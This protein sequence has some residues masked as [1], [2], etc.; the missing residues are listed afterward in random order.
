MKEKYNDIG[1]TY[2]Q[3]RKADKR[4][5]QRIINELELDPGSK[6]LDV[7]AGTGNY[8]YELAKIGYEITALEPSEVMIN[9]GK[10]HDNLKWYKGIAEEIPFSEKTFDGITCILST[11]H[12]KDLRKS[13]DEIKRVL[14]DNG[15]AVIFTADPRLCP[16]NFWY[17]NY[18]KD[19]IEKSYKI[20]PPAQELKAMLAKAFNNNVEMTTFLIPYDLQDGF[21]F[22]AWRYPE[23][24]LDMTFCNGISSLAET[25][26][27]ILIK[28]QEKLRDD[29]NNGNWQYRYRNILNSNE[30][31][32]GYLFLRVKAPRLPWL[33]QGRGGEPII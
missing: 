16:N 17:N 18:F 28:T 2:N 21:F 30:Y 20:H 23:R 29:L 1:K 8:S 3:T 33:G 26:K 22:S 7:G 13:F 4:I 12:F 19:I 25:P 24:Y 27:D 10:K 15:V 5:L 31:D 9:Q 32:C 14:K 6:I 11:H